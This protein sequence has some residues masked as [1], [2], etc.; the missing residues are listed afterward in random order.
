MT[1][2]ELCA[3]A[4]KYGALSTP[5]GQVE[6]AAIVDERAKQFQLT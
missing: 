2:N 5:E 6:I 3:N 4:V 1:R